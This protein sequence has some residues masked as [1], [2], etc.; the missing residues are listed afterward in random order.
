MRGRISAAAAGIATRPFVNSRMKY[1]STIVIN[2]FRAV[3][4]S[5]QRS[6]GAPSGREQRIEVSHEAIDLLGQVSG[7]TV[8]N[9]ARSITIE[10][11]D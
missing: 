9:R 8:I 10:P 4:R 3:D 1:V 5:A 2:A 7:T 11:R 6:A